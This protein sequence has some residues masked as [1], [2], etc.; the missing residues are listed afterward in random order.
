MEFL[1]RAQ[2]FLAFFD[3]VGQ[4]LLDVNVLA[5]LEGV[6]QH[7]GV[8][9]L[10]R[11]DDDRVDTLVLQQLAIVGIALGRIAAESLHTGGG[12]RQVPGI[13]IADGRHRGRLLVAGVKALQQL[14][15]A[16]ADADHTDRD[17]I[18]GSGRSRRERRCQCCRRTA[19][20]KA[21]P[22]HFARQ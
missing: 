14:A 22:A 12:L 15:P 16:N 18:V 21:S 1:G 4:R 8:Q 20:Q 11:G 10:G 3:G 9:M 17:L 5:G 19:S 13:R 6:D 2:N 7:G